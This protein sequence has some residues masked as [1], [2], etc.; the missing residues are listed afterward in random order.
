MCV[1]S[2]AIGTHMDIGSGCADTLV[3]CAQTVAKG[4]ASNNNAVLGQPLKLGKSLVYLTD[5][6]LLPS[7]SG[8]AVP[9]P[10]KRRR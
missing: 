3:S 10:A 4:L 8:G 9:N 1:F 2:D 6:V 5:T 7:G